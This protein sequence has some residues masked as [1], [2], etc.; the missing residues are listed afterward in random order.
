MFSVIFV[1]ICVAL[2]LRYATFLS[3]CASIIQLS[4]NILSIWMLHTV[5][6]RILLESCLK[7][8]VA[9]SGIVAFASCY[10]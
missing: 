8:S 10:S 3:N 6:P 9:V 4:Y 1:C 5:T 2:S 7:E